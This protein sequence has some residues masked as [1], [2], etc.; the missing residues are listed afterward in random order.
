MSTISPSYMDQGLRQS[1]LG[2][3][4]SSF[5]QLITVFGFF[6]FPSDNNRSNNGS[7]DNDLSDNDHNVNN[8][9]SDYSGRS[10]T[11]TGAAPKQRQQRHHQQQR[12]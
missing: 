11:T 8:D 6:K 5:T 1:R 9:L 3:L 4:A 2:L 12:Q 7:T 10:A